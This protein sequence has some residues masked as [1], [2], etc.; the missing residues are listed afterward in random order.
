MKGKLVVGR[1]GRAWAVFRDGTRVSGLLQTAERAEQ[2]RD[3]I[4]QAEARKP[5]GCLC[6]GARFVSDGRHHR[7]CKQCRRHDAEPELASAG[8]WSAR[9]RAAD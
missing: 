1:V 6:C 7:L 9:R 4:R 8:G 5:R 3:A 2:R